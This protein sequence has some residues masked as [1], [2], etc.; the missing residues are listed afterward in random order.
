MSI[1]SEY[2]QIRQQI[3]EET[4]KEI[5]EFLKEKPHYLLSD[6]YYKR[7]VW[8]EFQEWNKNQEEMKK[9]FEWYHT[10]INGDKSEYLSE[11]ISIVERIFES[12]TSFSFVYTD[13]Y[14]SALREVI[15]A[16][17]EKTCR[18]DVGNPDKA[19]REICGMFF[20]Y[21]NKDD[22][23]LWCE[24]SL[25]KEDENAIYKIL[26]KY[27]TFGNSVRG[28]RNEIVDMMN[29]TYVWKNSNITEE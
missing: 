25:T 18:C 19:S 2:E 5:C 6:V 23:E 29:G 13:V 11:A 27:E 22:Y 20:N 9:F 16:A 26:E 17:K 3:G 7:S 4:Y 14:L 28:K 1:L 15:A 12:G 21:G 24:F 10:N 8:F